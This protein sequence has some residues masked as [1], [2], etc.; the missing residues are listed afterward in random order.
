VLEKDWNDSCEALELMAKRYHEDTT[1]LAKR[2]IVLEFK[3]KAAAPAIQRILKEATRLRHIATIREMLEGKRQLPSV[4]E[5]EGK[6]AAGVGKPADGA[7]P[8][9]AKKE[10]KK[11]EGTGEGECV[12]PAPG[13]VGCESKESTP[14]APA[15]SE[16]KLVYSTRDPRSLTES[17]DLV[18]RLR[19]VNA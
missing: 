15:V 1:E 10:K 17:V 18:N 13:K 2:L 5:E 7:A 11:G 3:E 6:K 9:M 8:A 16:A 12:A 14:A 19:T 4:S